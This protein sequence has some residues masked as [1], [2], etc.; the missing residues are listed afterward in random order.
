MSADFTT[1]DLYFDEAETLRE[2]KKKF[3]A[4]F[5]D[6]LESL[7][8][9]VQ[10]VIVSF[11]NTANLTDEDSFVISIDNNGVQKYGSIQ[12][13]KYGRKKIMVG[14]KDMFSLNYQK[15]KNNL[16]HYKFSVL[17]LKVDKGVI[18]Q[19]DYTKRSKTCKKFM[20]DKTVF[21]YGRKKK[22]E[23]ILST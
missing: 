13:A 2:L 9:T 7:N 11:N 14:S 3:I 21:N 5:I 6:K 23:L 12:F 4:R 20:E 17:G 16:S 8:I 18:K 15:I 1:D 22:I 19:I 10:Y